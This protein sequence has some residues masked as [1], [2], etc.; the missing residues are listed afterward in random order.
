ML[1][2]SPL[3]SVASLIIFFALSS[4]L[5]AGQASPLV[6]QPAV[7]APVIV[8]TH[9]Q[10]VEAGKKAEPPLIFQT[11]VSLEAPSSAAGA[12]AS[13]NTS[14]AD[15]DNGAQPGQTPGGQ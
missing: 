11:V 14:P 6:C 1:L 8:L 4:A 3:V 9:E 5:S 7:S 13:D 2:R 15:S 10:I 12:A